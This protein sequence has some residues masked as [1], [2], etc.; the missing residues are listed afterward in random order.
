MKCSDIQNNFSEYI[1][2]EAL[3]EITAAIDA[4]LAGCE[5]CRRELES[6]RAFVS[7]FAALGEE[8]L[9]FDFS[10]KLR[11]S[12]EAEAAARQKAKAGKKRVRIRALALAAACL[13]LVVGASAAIQGMRMGKSA[14]Y[15]TAAPAETP[16]MAY[17]DSY[18]Y[19]AG[20]GGQMRAQTAPEAE[21]FAADEEA[22]PEAAENGVGAKTRPEEAAIERKV[23]K[24]CSLSLKVD[25]FDKAYAA[26][27][28]L[29]Q[30]YGGY[31]VSAEQYDYEGATQR[32]GYISIR[33]DAGRLDQ[34]LAEIQS[35]GK[36]EN[37]NTY[38]S[39]VT[40]AYYD[41]EARLEQYQAQAERLTELY[42]RAD[43]ITDLIAIEAEL[44]RINAE[45][46][47]MAGT[48]RYYDELTALSLID[49][50]LYTPS[51]YTQSVEPLGWAGFWK[52]LG[53][54]F[55]NGVN[56]ALDFLAEL[57]VLLASILPALVLLALVVLAVILIVKGAK[58]RRARRGQ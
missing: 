39:D 31:V 12:L 4:H 53:A 19:D 21:L 58:R 10:V 3:P 14:S 6:Y 5:A 51:A 33:V 57:L 2:G 46:D 40:A 29:A 8:E 30:A 35:L 28:A 42:D 55:L 15:D 56:G 25:D 45:T 48:L 18:S 9:P 26:I 11:A 43:N 16:M 44:T 7:L 38:S 52:D 22:Y 13:V 27:G 47:A 54:G 37:S 36:V 49:V 41:T 32:N 50:N 1:D 34:A 24:N 17:N 20:E 23:I